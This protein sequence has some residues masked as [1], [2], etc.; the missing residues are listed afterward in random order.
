MRNLFFSLLAMCSAT[1]FAQETLFSFDKK[2][3]YKINIPDEYVAA[4]SGN[5]PIYFINYL[6]KDAL[7]GTSEGIESYG[8]SDFKRESFLINKNRFFDVYSNSLE[9]KLSIKTPYYYEGIPEEN[10]KPFTDNVFG[11]FVSIK[12]LNSSNTINGYT[13]NEYEMT[14][15]SSLETTKSTLCI[16]E[17]NKLDNVSLLIPNAK[18][19]GLLVRFDA[20]DFNGL[21]IE[22]TGE[23]NAKV[24][25]NEKEEITNFN[26]KLS[27]IKKE[28]ESSVANFNASDTVAVDSAAS[29]Y[30]QDNRYDDPINSYYSYQTSEN[31][32]VNNLFNN[33]AL[34]NYSLVYSDTDYDGKMDYDRNAAVKVAEA[35]TKQLVK[36][37]KKGKLATKEEIKELETILKKYFDDANKFKLEDNPSYD[38]TTMEAAASAIEA[39]IGDYYDD[40][41]S[42]YKSIDT[43]VID[44]AINNPGYEAYAKLTPDHCKDLTNK[45]PTF[46]DKSLKNDLYNYVGQ[47]CD[48][49]IYNTGGVSLNG[50][51]DSMR[52][53]ALDIINKYDK[54][55]KGDKE[56]LTTFFN[57]LD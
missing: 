54:L 52:K 2:V 33:I 20:G 53:S 28:Y 13:C 41:K 25:F 18:L 24:T 48:L 8:S 46:S 30:T 32:T 55:S 12:N 39:S 21:T 50:T 34:L 17:K 42:E 5:E 9:N 45:I 1:T 43:S 10:L 14:Y 11:K 56:K 47:I 6:S 49:Y 22:K 29:Y 4:L 16:D 35:S 51:I 3:T 37:F 26:T 27:K 23:A 38:D 7:L 31:N 40:Y 57:S 44:L 19:K 36:E 15:E